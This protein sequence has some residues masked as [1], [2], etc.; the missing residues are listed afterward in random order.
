MKTAPQAPVDGKDAEVVVYNS[1]QN[2][3]DGSSW[4]EYVLLKLFYLNS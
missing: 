3:D 4:F 1:E 2:P